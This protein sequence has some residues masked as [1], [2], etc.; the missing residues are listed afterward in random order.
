MFKSCLSDFPG[1]YMS[2]CLTDCF[3][4]RFAQQP[5]CQPGHTRHGLPSSSHG[6]G[7]WAQ[8]WIISSLRRM[9]WPKKEE[10]FGQKLRAPQR[11]SSNFTLA[12]PQWS[13]WAGSPLPQNMVPMTCSKPPHQRHAVVLNGVAE[14][15]GLS[16]A[17]CTLHGQLDRQR[18]CGMFRTFCSYQISSQTKKNTEQKMGSLPN[19]D[20]PVTPM[21]V[22]ILVIT[23][24]H[25]NV[26]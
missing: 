14:N 7:K 21:P 26:L 8:L 25:Y 19:R 9:V 4:S 16:I 11:Y 2:S 13:E 10:D 20:I 1:G 22:P 6:C 17:Q 24:S 5:A 3:S 23:K 15:A 18:S 12:Q